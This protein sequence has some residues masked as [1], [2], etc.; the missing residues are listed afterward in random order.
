M[1]GK[2]NMYSPKW[3]KAKKHLKSFT[4]ESLKD[5]IDFHV[6]NYRKAHDKLGR[7]VITVDKKEVLN[8]CT[9]TSDIALINKESEIRHKQDVDYD[10]HN[11]NQNL[12]IGIQAHNLVKDEGIFAQYDFFD[13]LEQYFKSPIDKSLA[14]TDMVIKILSLIDKRTGKRT[15]KKINEAIK[16]DNEVINYF[17]EIR[18]VA[19]GI[20]IHRVLS[21]KNN[22]PKVDD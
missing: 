5:R 11:Y 3:S 15:L 14:S 1:E 6:I 16:N 20:N 17:Y 9:I 12:E 10:V 7:A 13:S 8:M 18:C 22:K 4:C 19:E 2:N 21:N